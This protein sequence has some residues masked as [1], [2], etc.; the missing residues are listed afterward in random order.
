MF[1]SL[2]LHLLRF[3]GL[4][5][6]CAVRCAPYIAHYLVVVLTDFFLW[7][8]AKKV[9]V[10]EA[11]QLTMIL[12]FF[13]RFET[14]HLIRTLTNTVE[15]MFT[16]VGFYFYLGQKDKFCTNTVI[17][18]ALIT[19]S[20]MIRNTSP[21]GWV[22]LLAYKVLKEG[23]LVP[24]IISGIFVAIP[25]IGFL[26]FVDS[27]F[28]GSEKWV[29]TSYNFLEMNLLHGLSKYFGEDGPLYYFI[30]GYP[31]IFT[32]LVL[33]A[34]F[35][36]FSHIGFASQLG[37]VPYCSFYVI[38]YLGFY[39]LIAHKE[40]RFLM[41]CIPFV[42]MTTAELLHFTVVRSKPLVAFFWLWMYI[43]VEVITLSV[44]TLN[45]ERA[46]ILRASLF[47]EHADLHS[48]YSLDVYNTPTYS[49]MHREPPVKIYTPDKDC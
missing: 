24:F 21:V 44:M 25:L 38:F 43:F 41:P 49:L 17:L 3:L 28:Y 30:A 35:S 45:H 8:A 1:L 18:T 6:N 4:D 29:L 7:K 15:Q 2:P 42:M 22:P 26:I 11:A 27:Q 40:V 33:P 16:V 9:L 39:T 23:S 36:M 13:N 47:Q 48:F 10:R 12:F 46:S 32:L 19:V 37:K 5:S 34:L 31:A 14:M 20:F